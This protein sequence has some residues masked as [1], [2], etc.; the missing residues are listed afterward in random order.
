[1]AVGNLALK[2][3]VSAI[4]TTNGAAGPVYDSVST[5]YYPS[6]LLPISASGA[7]TLTLP[8]A[9]L[10]ATLLGGGNGQSLQFQNLAAQA[11]T[12]VAASGDSILGASTTIAQNGTATYIAD[13]PN[14]RWFR[15]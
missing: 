5:G 11:V 13:A 7:V 10:S 3:N 14:S 2:R 8:A 15:V 1:M 9:K 4:Y 6:D 12:I